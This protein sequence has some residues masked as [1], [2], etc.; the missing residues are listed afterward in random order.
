MMALGSQNKPIYLQ[1][2]YPNAGMYHVV[3]NTEGNIPCITLDSLNLHACDFIQLDVEGFE[4][5][6]IYGARQTIEKFKPVIALETMTMQITD[7]LTSIGY[8]LNKKS[9]HDKI[10][11]PT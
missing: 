7:Y 11:I 8:Q 6:V 10:W 9:K 2:N 5:H 3:E 4:A 1:N